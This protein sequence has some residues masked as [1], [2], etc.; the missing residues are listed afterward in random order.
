MSKKKYSEG[1][2]A[3][4]AIFG[5]ELAEIKTERESALSLSAMESKAAD[6]AP[7]PQSEPVEKKTKPKTTPK[8]DSP[9]KTTRKA[10]ISAVKP[11]ELRTK[12]VQLLIAPSIYEAVEKKRQAEG[13]KSL[14]DYINTI[15]ETIVK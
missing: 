1:L 12:R 15:L 13:F 3:T 14:N 11:K 7:T 8:A 4:A 10:A 5:D 2:N 9:K 6:A